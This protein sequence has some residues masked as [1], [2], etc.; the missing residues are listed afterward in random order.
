VPR[1]GKSVHGALLVLRV[2]PDLTVGI[3]MGGLSHIMRERAEVTNG[4][5]EHTVSPVPNIRAECS[6]AARTDR[7]GQHYGSCDDGLVVGPL[8][9]ASPDGMREAHATIRTRRRRRRER[10]FMRLYCGFTAFDPPIHRTLDAATRLGSRKHPASNALLEALLCEADPPRQHAL[11]GSTP[12]EGGGAASVRSP[13][14][15][16]QLM[17]MNRTPPAPAFA[18]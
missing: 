2:P 14:L 4:G 15:G 16:G 7:P 11:C 9:P 8:T 12:Q 6:G 17:T 13:R 5:H 1:V 3:D 10:S 18:N